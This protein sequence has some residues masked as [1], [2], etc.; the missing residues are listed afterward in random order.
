MSELRTLVV[1]DRFIPAEDYRAAFARRADERISL[2]SVDWSGGKADQH[3]TQ[4]LMEQ[5]GANAVPAPAELVGAIGDAQALCLHFAPVGEVLLAAAPELR[6]IAVARSGLQNVDV[7]AATEAGVGVVPAHGR[8]A[9]AVAEL[10]LGLMLSEARDIARAD[11]S[12]K[13]G[14]W[15]KDFPGV[16]FELAGKTIGMV[17][18]GHVGTAFA[19]RISG[20]GCTLLAYDP[21]APDEL[22]AVHG[23]RRAARLDEVFAGSDVVCVQARLT[24]DT[25]RLVTAEHFALMPAHAYFINT[26]RSRVVDYDALYEVLAAGR[27]AGAGLD[28]FDD[29][30]LPAGSPWRR[31]DNV[32]ITTHFAGDTADTNRVSANLVAEAVAEF[33]RTGTVPWAANAAEL[34]WT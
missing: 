33:A 29:E 24:P 8:N 7:A 6:L 11:A 27:I 19:A 31:L 13:N 10:Q 18:F 26:S 2:R 23:V 21:Y 9:G 1:G 30:P 14:L 20:F 32:T 3:E 16:C 22:L 17:G 5:R 15:R 25:E 4:Q 12:V 34:G 28:V